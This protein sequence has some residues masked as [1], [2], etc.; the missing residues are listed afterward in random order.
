MANLLN[1]VKIIGQIESTHLAMLESRCIMTGIRRGMYDDAQF[2]ART[3]ILNMNPSPEMGTELG[4]SRDITEGSEQDA[5]Q[6]LKRLNKAMQSFQTGS[7]TADR[8]EFFLQYL[9]KEIGSLRYEW[10]RML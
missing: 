1:E 4:L 2:Q 7:D 9:Q 10:P 6:S 5:P 8:R 3:I